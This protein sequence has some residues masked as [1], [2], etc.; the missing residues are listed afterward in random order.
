MLEFPSA[1]SESDLTTL[2]WRGLARV[3]KSLTKDTF[4]V[5]INEEL[6]SRLAVKEQTYNLLTSISL[7]SRDVPRKLRL[8]DDV[9]IRFLSGNFPSRF[10]S[11]DE[12]LRSHHIQ[13]P[14][15]PNDYCK[16]VVKVK[17]KSPAAA[18]NKGLRSLDFVR[19][20][21]CLAGNPSMQIKFGGTSM[22]PINV[23]RVGSRHTVHLENG[24]PAT[25]DTIWFEPNFKESSIF[26]MES[27]KFTKFLLWGLR[28]I[29]S[30]SYAESITAA[31]IRYVRALDESDPNTAFLRLWGALEM[32]TSPGQADYD[33]LVQRCTFLFMD[34]EFHRQLLEH[35]RE[36][37]NRSVHAGEES[38]QA[39]T[40]CFQLQF[41]FSVLVKFHIASVQYF[42]TLDEAN[43]FLDSP[44]E[45]GELERRVELARKALKFRGQETAN[46]KKK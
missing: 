21:L 33:K 46:R 29:A 17:A 23:V 41:F 31:L 37:R 43:F 10:K 35:L 11:R 3:G 8:N 45:K 2:V 7:D 19:A 36:Y 44:I 5:A 1:A 13:V 39:R 27:P 20:L 25:I 24:E 22:S 38:E 15:A 42:R 28:Q 18:V 30:S 16:I 9:E 32:L 40:H 6:D 26:R 12:L 4:L 34:T 14:P